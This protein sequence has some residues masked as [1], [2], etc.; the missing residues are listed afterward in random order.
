M[1][2]PK[3][4]TACLLSR[5]LPSRGYRSRRHLRCDT[6]LI[7]SRSRSLEEGSLRIPVGLSHLECQSL[8]APFQTSLS[9]SCLAAKCPSA[10]ST[11]SRLAECRCSGMG[12]DSLSVLA[13][14]H[15]TTKLTMET[16]PLVRAIIQSLNSA[17]GIYRQ[18]WLVESLSSL[19][20]ATRLRV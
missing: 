9:P 3:P 17:R 20:Q 18:F 19:S 7:K 14:L 13:A 11:T 8:L 6:H 2:F 4:E 12:K 5:P 16:A 15:T 1:P 10:P